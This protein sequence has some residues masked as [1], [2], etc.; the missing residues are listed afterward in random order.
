MTTRP[1]AD[2]GR[3]SDSP[4]GREESLGSAGQPLVGDGDVYHLTDGQGVTFAIG[5]RRVGECTAI[6]YPFD[7]ER[8]NLK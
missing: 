2:S 8:K 4:P 3:G 7:H 5:G 1:L 6:A